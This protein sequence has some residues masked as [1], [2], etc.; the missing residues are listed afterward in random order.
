ME[1]VISSREAVL[2]TFTGAREAQV[3]PR[4]AAREMQ[5][6]SGGRQPFLVATRETPQGPIKRGDLPW[7]PTVRLSV[8]KPLRGAKMPTFPSLANPGFRP[9]RVPNSVADP[10]SNFFR[11][12]PKRWAESE[13]DLAGG[14]QVLGD[15]CLEPIAK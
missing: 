4:T 11:E 15:Q 7:R 14:G 12:A 6:L 8:A 13:P 10:A 9:R 2:Q 3:R 5:I 1:E